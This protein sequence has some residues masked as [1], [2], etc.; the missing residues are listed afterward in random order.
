MIRAPAQYF[1]R[2]VGISEDD[3]WAYAWGKKPL[4]P[5]LA[6]ALVA[7]FFPLVAPEELETGLPSVPNDAK[8]RDMSQA[9]AFEIR[10]RKVGRPIESDHQFSQWLRRRNITMTEW[11]ADHIDPN[12]GKAYKRERVKSWVASGDGGRPIPEETAKVIEEESRDP[13]TG[14]PAVPALKRCWPN[15][16][17]R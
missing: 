15:G 1:A 13:K 16:I 14:K 8:V 9:P 10:A 17:R 7:E 5:G 2:R 6:P 3:Y 4:P 12:T 11:A